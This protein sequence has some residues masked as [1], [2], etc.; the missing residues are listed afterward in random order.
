MGGVIRYIIKTYFNNF[1]Q[2]CQIVAGILTY[3]NTANMLWGPFE[4][5]KLL[6]MNFVLPA[7]G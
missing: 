5:H 2:V 1:K 6:N 7:S 3:L 4:F